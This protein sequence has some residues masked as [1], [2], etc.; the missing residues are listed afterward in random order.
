MGTV[1][2][3][4]VDIHTTPAPQPSLP[5][6]FAEIVLIA[7]YLR[8]HGHLDVLSNQVHLVRK[9]FGHYEVMD[10]LALLFGYAISGERTLQAFF[11]RLQ[12]FAEPFMALF[13]RGALPHR[14]TLSRFLAAI[15]SSCLEA[16]RAV[17]TDVFCR[18]GMDTGDALVVCGT[19]RASGIWS[20]LS[21]R[22]AKP[23]ASASS[24]VA[25]DFLQPNGALTRCVDRAIWGTGAER[26]CAPARRCYRCIPGNG[27]AVLA[28]GAMATIGANCRRPWQ[29]SLL[30]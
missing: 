2:H 24:P 26:S 29:R 22:L 14:S 20:L 4:C 27:W 19:E 10:F 8:S 28:V 21:M 16:L 30:I 1:P 15:D 7:G 18:L 23:L 6:W 9:R 3:P 25:R 11:D 13:E 17:C 5:P 12:P